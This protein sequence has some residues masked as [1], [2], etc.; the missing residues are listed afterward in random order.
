MVYPR[1]YGGNSVSTEAATVISG[2]SPR[3]RG[4]LEL[5]VDGETRVWSIPAC[6][7]ETTISIMSDN[8]TRVYPRVYGGNSLRY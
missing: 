8:N 4:K 2:L 7:G 5:N 3:V 6:T 1:V